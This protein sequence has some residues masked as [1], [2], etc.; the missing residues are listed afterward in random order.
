MYSTS[1][2]RVA[3][4]VNVAVSNLAT[5]VSELDEASGTKFITILDTSYALSI[6]KTLPDTT[7][8][9]LAST[10]R[11]TFESPVFTS[12]SLTVT[13]LLAFVKPKPTAFLRI[14]L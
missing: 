1:G 4:Y 5:T 11:F 9:F 14:A 8:V 3:E 2:S 6:P 7:Y 10:S 13:F 12:S